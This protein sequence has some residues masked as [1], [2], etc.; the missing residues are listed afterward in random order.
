M[1]RV[2]GAV[3][4]GVPV[5]PVNR[6]GRHARS[7]STSCR[8]VARSGVRRP[9]GGRPPSATG[10]WPTAASTTA[11]ALIVVYTSGTTGPPKGVV[12]PAPGDRLHAG[13]AGGRLAVDADDVLV[14]GLP[15]FHVH[16]L[17]LG[18]LGPLRRGGGCAT[19][20]GSPPR[21]GA[22]LGGPARRCCS[23]YR[24]CTTGSPRSSGG[25]IAT[26]RALGRR[27]A[28]GVG[29]GGAAGARPRADRGREPGSVVER[30]G[31][32]ETLMNTSVRADGEPPA[33]GRSGVRWPGCRGAARGRGGGGLDVWTTRRGRRDPG[34]RPEPVHR[35]PEP[36]GRDGGGVRA[37]AGSAPATWR[38]ATP[39]ATSGSSAARRPT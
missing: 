13:R 29:F 4:V 38:P 3:A 7:W 11:P 27:A 10:D 20:G 18:V 9:G 33:R 6:Q 14:H 16:G 23:A 28:A 8:L 39:T 24:R 31:M 36:A 2:V 32:T 37:T 17:I 35:V 19:W 5:V 34:A 15:L 22:A 1:S 12:L 26:G 21:G 30:Y 25:G